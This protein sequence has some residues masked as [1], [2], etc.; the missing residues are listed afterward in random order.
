MDGSIVLPGG[1]LKRT[2]EGK[3]GVVF[4]ESPEEKA[5][6]KW[7][8]GRFDEAEEALA[9]RWRE[10]TRMIDL[11]QIKSKVKSFLHEGHHISSFEE[12]LRVIDDSSSVPHMQV[13][14]LRYAIEEFDV[15]QPRASEAFYRWE[16]GRWTD[17]RSF[18]PYA[19]FCVRVT[20]AFYLALASDIVTTRPTNR[21]DL[22]YLYYLPFTMVFSSRDKFHALLAPDLLREDQTFIDGDN[23][24]S[25]L[26]GLA[27]NWIQMDE[28]QRAEWLESYRDYPPNDESPMIHNLWQKYMRPE[29]NIREGPKLADIG[30]GKRDEFVEMVKTLKNS[31]DLGSGDGTEIDLNTMD[32]VISERM[33]FPDDPCPC[34][35]GKTLRDCHFSRVKNK[36]RD[37]EEPS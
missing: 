14:F 17:F 9:E 15:S 29:Q 2:E 8:L 4:E 22:E 21:I 6:N 30:S 31:E 5:I 1:S 27:D 36:R 33:I 25:D 35:S 20:T 32:F 18:A 13:L 16:S 34:G 28:S 24:K 3:R 11:G 26:K 23:L 7:R 10:S 37:S 12:V 19:A